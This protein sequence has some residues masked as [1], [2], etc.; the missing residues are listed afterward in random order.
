MKIISTL[1]IFLILIVSITAC[2]EK[3]DRRKINAKRDSINILNSKKD[4]DL[5]R[6]NKVIENN[7][8]NKVQNPGVIKGKRIKL[9]SWNNTKTKRR[10]IDFVKN[11]T[12]KNSSNFVQPKDRIAVFDADGTLWAEYP[13]YFQ[14]EFVLYRIKKLLPEH[15]EWK[16]DELIQTVIKHDLKVLREKFGAK[17]LGK[18]MAISQQDMTTEEFEITVVDWYNNGI[19]SLTGMPFSKMVY[20]PI[21]QLIKYLKQYDFKIYLVAN[22]GNDFL[23]P[24]SEKAF[25]IKKEHIIGSYG[26][27]KYQKIDKN[28]VLIKSPEIEFAND[29]EN[30]VIAIHRKIG[31][32]PLI[33]IGNADG[34]LQMLEWCASNEKINLPLF[35]HHTDKKREWA[36]DRESRVGKLDNGLDEANRK[37]W[38]IVDMAKDWKT[39]YSVE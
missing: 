37:N 1:L 6:V 13:T 29:G 24:I 39:I 23:Q 9:S 20:Q 8:I 26:K 16:K 11:V 30:K 21:K 32:K 18:L 17:G 3:E 4:I 22:S 10:I 15:P 33:A 31:K 27:L 28:P 7:N 25:G 5:T 12:T 34:D 19:N 14:I 35:I 38:L 2:Y 36:Y